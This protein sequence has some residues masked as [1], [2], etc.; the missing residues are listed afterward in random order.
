M[1]DELRIIWYSFLG[2]GI[3]RIGISACPKEL[4][5]VK[6][7]SPSTCSLIQVKASKL[8]LFPFCKLFVMFLFFIITIRLNGYEF[9]FSLSPSTVM[10][11]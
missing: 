7:F 3:R 5:F 11:T 8:N 1:K 9:F 6:S 10:Y 2:K 4:T